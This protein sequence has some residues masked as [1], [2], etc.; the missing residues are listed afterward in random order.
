MELPSGL[1]H[2]C[3]A[4]VSS[5]IITHEAEHWWLVPA[6]ELV[7]CMFHY[8]L[9]AFLRQFQD[10]SQTLPDARLRGLRIVYGVAFMMA[11][12]PHWVVSIISCTAGLWPGLFDRRFARRLHPSNI[13][14]P[15]SPFTGKKVKDSAEGFRWL[16]QWDHIVGTA[17]TMLWA[18]TLYWDCQS[19]LPM[20]R[21]V[22]SVLAKVLVYAFVGGPMGVPIGL[23]WERDEILLSIATA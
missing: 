5:G 18:A 19:L 12:I 9:V 22:R 20:Q 4:H 8:L 2:S 15:T 17:A 23:L 1:H 6:M 11:A 14:M 21:G 16:I 10:E 13:L 7:H 3:Y